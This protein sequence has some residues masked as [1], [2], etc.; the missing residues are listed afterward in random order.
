LDAIIAEQSASGALEELEGERMVLRE[1]GSATGVFG[2]R[3]TNR[4]RFAAY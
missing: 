2:K 3:S 4:R 1:Q